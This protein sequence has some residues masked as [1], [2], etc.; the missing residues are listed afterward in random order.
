LRWIVWKLASTE[1]RFAFSLAQSY[2]TYDHVATQLYQR[3]EK[4]LKGGNRSALRKVLNRDVAASSMMILCIS[5]I[6]RQ[7]K[8]KDEATKGPTHSE[9]MLELTD[10]WYSI[11][12]IVDARLG[13]FVSNGKIK[14]GSKLLLCNAKL[15]GP[16][17]G[18]DPLDTSYSSSGRNCSA[19]LSLITNGTRLAKWDAKMGFVKPCRGTRSNCGSL[20]VRSISHIVP[21]GGDVPL[22]DL[23][24][25][26]LYPLMFLERRGANNTKEM[27]EKLAGKSPVISEAQEYKNRMKFE[28]QRHQA[29][30][31]LSETV[32]SECTKVRQRELLETSLSTLV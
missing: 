30:E 2:L 25:C 4:E 26:R 27:L 28:K 20:L 29:M 22:I 24:V 18:I 15:E 14:V 23:V 31:R 17:D 21:G 12:G 16:E 9:W 5:Q 13:A 32:Q 7:S 8:R 6:E 10:G 3:Y 19:A 1:R 11:G